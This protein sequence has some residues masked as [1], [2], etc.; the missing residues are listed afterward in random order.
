MTSNK[1]KFNY[2]VIDHIE[3]YN[4]NIDHINI[5]GCGGGAPGA[6]ARRG[7]GGAG[8]GTRTPRPSSAGRCCG[9]DG[10]ASPAGG[11]RARR[12][13]RASPP[14]APRRPP[15]SKRPS[16]PVRRPISEPFLFVCCRMRCWLPV[17]AQC[18]P[19]VCTYMLCV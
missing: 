10:G 13:A 14:S 15:S 12:P 11:T 4:F 19:T 16:T 17:A 18:C 1:K 3:N 5:Q 6:G 9:I 2:K 8:R 7:R